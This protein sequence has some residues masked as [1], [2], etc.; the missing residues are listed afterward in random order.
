[1]NSLELAKKRAEIEKSKAKRSKL[2]E[3]IKAIEYLLFE[4]SFTLKQIQNFLEEDCNCK[5]AY[6]SLHAFCKRRFK[7]IDTNLEKVKETS[8]EEKKPIDNNTKTNSKTSLEQD[9]LDFVNTLKR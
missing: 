2:D 4:E 3:H 5:V 6:S 9:M 1:M 7:N 8:Q